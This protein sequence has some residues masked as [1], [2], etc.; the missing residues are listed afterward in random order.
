MYITTGLLNVM[1]IEVKYISLTGYV[2]HENPLH[3]KP[4]FKT[5]KTD[6]EI[7]YM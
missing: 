1:I 4:N 7:K 2:Q 5:K 3:Q 6:D